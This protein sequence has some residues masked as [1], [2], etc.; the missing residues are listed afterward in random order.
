MLPGAALDMTTAAESARIYRA[1]GPVA[2]LI[3]AGQCA[4]LGREQ[5]Q[6]APLSEIE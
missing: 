3:A 5:F 1:P 6:D 2:R 4:A